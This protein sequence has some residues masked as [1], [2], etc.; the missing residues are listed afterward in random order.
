MIDATVWMNLENIMLDERIQTKESPYTVLFH[1]Y[2]M[3]M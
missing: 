3:F 2:K 1:L